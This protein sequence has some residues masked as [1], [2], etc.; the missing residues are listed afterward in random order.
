MEEERWDLMYTQYAVCPYCGDEDV[1]SFELNCDDEK[2]V[3]CPS[4]GKQ[5]GVVRNVEITYTTWGV[6]NGEEE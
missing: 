3:C 6:D 2:I 5:Y 1:D 4:C